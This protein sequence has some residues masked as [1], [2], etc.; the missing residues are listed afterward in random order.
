MMSG[1]NG[2]RLSRLEEFGARAEAPS[3]VALSSFAFIT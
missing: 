3:S 2:M 1:V